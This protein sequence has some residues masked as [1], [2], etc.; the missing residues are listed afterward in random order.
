VTDLPAATFDVVLAVDTIH[1]LGDPAATLAA[2][3]ASLTPGGVF[4][5]AEL[6]ATGDF[7]LDRH[8][9]AR[10]HYFASLAMCIPVSQ[11]A[12]GPGLGSFWG[13]AGALPMLS[14]AGFTAVSVHSAPPGYA[15]YAA[16]VGG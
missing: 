15:V 9:D 2:I 6:D 3:A 12:G 5:M 16:R 7:D 10:H 11:S 14:E 4:V 8:S 13:R 1:D